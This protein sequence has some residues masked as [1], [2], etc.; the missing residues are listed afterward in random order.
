MIDR[1]IQSER[2]T[3]AYIHTYRRRDSARLTNIHTYIYT[4]NLT[5]GHTGRRADNKTQTGNH[6]DR[7]R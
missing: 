3:Q 2:Q 6:T 4:D 7:H 5:D 1:D